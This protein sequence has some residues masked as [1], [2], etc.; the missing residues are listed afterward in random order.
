ML[1]IHTHDDFELVEFSLFPR[2]KMD[3]GRLAFGLVS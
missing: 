3:L 1:S 2:E